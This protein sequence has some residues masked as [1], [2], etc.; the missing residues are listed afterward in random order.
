MR[1]GKFNIKNKNIPTTCWRVLFED[2]EEVTV[3]DDNNKEIIKDKLEIKYNKKVIEI[4]ESD[5]LTLI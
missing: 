4:I 5:D 3:L 1:E 2:G